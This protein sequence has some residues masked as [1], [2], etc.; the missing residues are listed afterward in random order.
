[1]NSISV[2]GIEDAPIEIQLEGN[3]AA[4]DNQALT[5][6]FCFKK[7]DDNKNERIAYRADGTTKVNIDLFNLNDYIGGGNTK[8]IRIG[9]YC[10][11]ELYFNIR[12]F[13]LEKA[14]NTLI[15]NFYLGKEVNN[16]Q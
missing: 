13:T 1:M 15:V 3:N 16:G 4:D 5:F 14:S 9:T 7:D 10:R 6:V 12:V 8:L 2:I 11:R